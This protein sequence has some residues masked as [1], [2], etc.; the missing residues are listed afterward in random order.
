M[1]IEQMGLCYT[2]FYKTW[3]MLDDKLD[4]DSPNDYLFPWIVNGA[5]ACEIGMKYILANN[6][7]DFKKI[8]LLGD[9]YNLLPDNHKTDIS[10]E[11]FERCPQYTIEQFNQEILLLSN[12][13]CD[14]RYCY[15]YSLSINTTF[16][17][18]WCV[19]IFKQVNQY[20]L[21]KLVKCADINNIS[22]DE[23]DEK[24]LNAHNEALSRL[25]RKKRKYS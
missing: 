7:I 24:V 9:L 18:I 3:C 10:K 14:Y 17:K 25:N 4:V 20:P 11:L 1:M 6:G 8:H 5:F 16:F 23:F 19:A 13:F 2:Q 21:Y 12:S 15:E 22:L